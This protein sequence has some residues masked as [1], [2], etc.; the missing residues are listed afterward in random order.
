M[1][2]KGQR[3]LTKFCHHNFQFFVLNTCREIFENLAENKN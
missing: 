1:Y 3:D 2:M